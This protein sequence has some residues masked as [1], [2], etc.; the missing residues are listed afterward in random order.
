MGVVSVDVVHP[1]C[2][3]DIVTAWNK[4]RFIL[5]DK[6]DFRMIDHLS[7]AVPKFSNRINKML[8]SLV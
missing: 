3:I 6:L 1:Y 4:T 7:I 2:S 5:S 8:V